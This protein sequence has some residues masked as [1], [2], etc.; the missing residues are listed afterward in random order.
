MYEE[1]T[2]NVCVNAQDDCYAKINDA[3]HIGIWKRG[4]VI[5]ISVWGIEVLLIS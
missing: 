1:T 2:L 5:E 3:L 4:L